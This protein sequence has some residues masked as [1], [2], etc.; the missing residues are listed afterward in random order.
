MRHAHSLVRFMGV[1]VASM[2]LIGGAPAQASGT[3]PVLCTGFTGCQTLGR[4]EA[5]YGAVHQQ[6][7]W[8][9]TAGHNCTNYVAYRLTH[10]RLVARPYGTNSALT[11][12]AAASR[13]GIPVDDRPAVGSVAWWDAGVGGVSKTSGHV[14]YVEAVQQDGSIVV[15]EDNLS[16]DFAWR[17]V[18]RHD[19]RW[20][21]GFIHYPE[22]DGSPS[23]ELLS[24]ASPKPGQLD[25]YG[26]SADPDAR[27]GERSYLVTL[28]GPRGTPG[29]EQ[30]TFRSEWLRFHRIHSVATR[31]RT[32]MYLYALNESGTAGRDAFLGRRDVTIRSASATRATL[33]DRSIPRRVSPKVRLSLA[34]SRA[35]GRVE[36]VRGSTVIKRVTLTAGQRRTVALPRQRAGKWTLRV[37]YRS[38]PTFAASSRTLRLRV[39]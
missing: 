2:L 15:S 26:T 4:S 18:T 38:T 35:S 21:S 5:G 19:G 31:G 22:S 14:A 29:V 28:G 6:S 13:V 23:G 27:A 10:G 33:L 8:N 11:W 24:V 9:M 30:F 25:F 12:G 20:P 17:V 3:T 1:V 34:P 39:R 16:G 36:I 7:F 32:T 37:R